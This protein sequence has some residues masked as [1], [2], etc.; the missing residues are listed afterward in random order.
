MRTPQG[1]AECYVRRWTLRLHRLRAVWQA[2]LCFRFRSILPHR[3]A[4]CISPTREL[5]AHDGAQFQSIYCCSHA[6][7]AFNPGSVIAPRR[8]G[9]DTRLEDRLSYSYRL[10]VARHLGGIDGLRRQQC[11][12]EIPWFGK[13]FFLVAGPAA[14]IAF[15]RLQEGV[16]ALGTA[17]GIDPFQQFNNRSGT[18]LTRA[19]DV[20]MIARHRDPEVAAINR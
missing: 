8:H 16:E 15:A 11:L 18:Q 13:R 6:L 9:L 4:T 19:M 14:E 10:C 17:E 20:A 2:P 5:D 1:K 3:L 7:F 12:A